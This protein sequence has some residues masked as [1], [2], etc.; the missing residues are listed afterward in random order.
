V[1]RAVEAHCS[2]LKIGFSSHDNVGKLIGE[3]IECILTKTW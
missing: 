2:D 3:P 1:W